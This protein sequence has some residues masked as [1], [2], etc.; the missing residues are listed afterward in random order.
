[1]LV[2]LLAAAPSQLTSLLL[3]GNPVAAMVTFMVI[4]RPLIMML[5]G[6]ADTDAPRF[7]VK[8]GFPYKKKTGRRASS[9]RKKRKKRSRNGSPKRQP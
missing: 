2:A 7:P 9:T 5:T 4:A 3:P 1:M 6:A 8:A